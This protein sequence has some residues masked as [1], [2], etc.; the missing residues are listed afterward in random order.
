MLFTAKL[1]ED[2]PAGKIMIG[3]AATG[4]AFIFISILIPELNDL[5]PFFF[6]TLLIS[7]GVMAIIAK[8]DLSNYKLI[9]D[10]TVFVDGMQISQLV[11][12]FQELSELSFEFQSYQEVEEIYN[13]GR[14]GYKSY[15]LG[16]NLSFNY[17]NQAFHYQFYL[18]SRQHYVAFVRM[19][20]V[21]YE[22]QVSFSEKNLQGATFLMR[23]VDAEQLQLLQRQ[24]RRVR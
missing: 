3:V 8:G 7:V 4:I 11:F 12:P 14:R 21:L 24:Y 22:H 13:G 1:V 18:Q 19:L 2:R 5:V 23:N 10:F 6:T 20:E 16:N 15:G 9:N 17:R